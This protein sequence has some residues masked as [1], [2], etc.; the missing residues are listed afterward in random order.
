MMY[1]VHPHPGATSTNSS[2]L[3]MSSIGYITQSP[4]ILLRT[5]QKICAACQILLPCAK[6]TDPSIISYTQSLIV[7]TK[8]LQSLPTLSTTLN[9][10][11]TLYYSSPSP[12]LLTSPIHLFIHTR[13]GLSVGKPTCQHPFPITLS[14]KPKK[15]PK[16]GLASMIFTSCCD[17]SLTS[18]P[19]PQNGQI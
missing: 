10:S 3:L 1:V 14:P 13:V 5:R 15:D 2:S 16:Q 8:H 9:S 7:C 19:S 17:P 18:C 11:I 12:L 4:K 6:S